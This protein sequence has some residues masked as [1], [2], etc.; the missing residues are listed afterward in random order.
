MTFI[1]APCY[2]GLLMRNLQPCGYTADRADPTG[3]C[4]EFV[5][6]QVTPITV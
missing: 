4:I 6:Y 3:R 5:D 2:K 1:T